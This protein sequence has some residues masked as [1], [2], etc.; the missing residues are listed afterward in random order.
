MFQG[1]I[2][3]KQKLIKENNLNIAHIVP[4]IKYRINKKHLNTFINIKLKKIN[5]TNMF[6]LKCIYFLF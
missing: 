3:K 5:N 1:N 2:H 4:N 6:I